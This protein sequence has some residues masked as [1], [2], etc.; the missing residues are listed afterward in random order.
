[1]RNIFPWKLY[2]QCSGETIPRT[3]SKNSKLSI[4]LDTYNK[5][6]DSL[7]FLYPKGYQIILKLSCRPLAFT[8][9][10]IFQKTKRGMEL[11]SLPHFLHDF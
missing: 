7:F 4:S 3:L 2:T 6:L 11:A 8:S 5:L 10:K 1:M 9:Y